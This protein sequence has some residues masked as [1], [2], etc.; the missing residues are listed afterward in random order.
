MVLWW[1]G[2]A[3]TPNP[4]QSPTSCINETRKK[5]KRHIIIMLLG[6]WLRPDLLH[7]GPTA[8]PL[9]SRPPKTHKK[10]VFFNYATFRQHGVY[11]PQHGPQHGVQI[12]ELSL[13]FPSA[14]FWYRETLNISS[15]VDHPEEINWV[16]Y[17]VLI[18]WMQSRSLSC[19]AWQQI[20]HRCTCQTNFSIWQVLKIE[21]I[22]WW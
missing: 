14:F 1:Y 19:H 12:R 18:I 11:G 3:Q 17:H 4:R 22:A 2:R 16:R 9:R 10:H 20:C 7:G 6:H 15:D 5:L 8:P 21:Y 13:I